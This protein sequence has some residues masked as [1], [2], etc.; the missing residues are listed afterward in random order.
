MV[1]TYIHIWHKSL[2]VCIHCIVCFFLCTCVDNA[3]LTRY[4]GRGLFLDPP[5]AA[6]VDGTWQ[7]MA[8]AGVLGQAAVSHTIASRDA[9][10]DYDARWVRDTLVDCTTCTPALPPHRT[11]HPGRTPLQ[12]TARLSPVQWTSTSASQGPTLAP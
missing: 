12:H 6:M 1:T 8:P 9:L 4:R 7:L 3:L 5:Q 11:P 2:Y 10:F